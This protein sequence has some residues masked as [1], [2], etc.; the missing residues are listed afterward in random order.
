VIKSETAYEVHSCLVDALQSGTGKPAYSRFGLKKFPAAG[1]TGTAYDFTDALF[2]GY[3]SAITC[4][5]WAGFDKPQ[6]IYRGAFGHEIALPVWVNVMNASM[7]HYQPK[8]LQPPPTIKKTEICLRSGLL[9]TDKCYDTVKGPNG[10]PMLRR[11]TYVEIGTEKQLP[12]DQCNVHGEAKA[13][14]VKET[15]ESEFPRAASAVDLNSIPVVVPKAAVLLADKDPYNAVRALV[16]PTPEPEASPEPTTEIVAKPAE[17][18]TEAEASPT[19]TTAEGIPVRKALAPDAATPT[20]AVTPTGVI[21]RT[22]PPGAPVMKA[23]PVQPQQPTPAEIRKAVPVGPLDEEE[24]D[25]SLLKKAT[26]PP[27]KVD[28]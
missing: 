7:E 17:R 6:K 13:R 20:T 11:T 1:K 3:D 26:P 12:T 9:A 23:I 24:D 27:A 2:A 28:E 22:P 19:R 18:A 16:K 25:E 15:G 5:V 14:L 8:E 4:V 10:E 21:A